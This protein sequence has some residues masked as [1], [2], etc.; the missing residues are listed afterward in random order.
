MFTKQPRNQGVYDIEEKIK[1]AFP[2]S[3]H[4]KETQFIKKL[5]SA[6]NT[7]TEE[8][9]KIFNFGEGARSKVQFTQYPNVCQNNRQ[10]FDTTGIFKTISQVDSLA[11]KVGSEILQFLLIV[12]KNMPLSR[13]SVRWK[14]RENERNFRGQL[15]LLQMDVKDACDLLNK[16][17]I[18]ALTFD[19]DM[20]SLIEDFDADDQRQIAG[21]VIDDLLESGE[22]DR[23]KNRLAVAK[24][25]KYGAMYSKLKAVE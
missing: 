25:R 3:D 22:V 11:H 16:R 1:K 20:K 7:V 24:V 13:R 8:D 19:N 15:L 21:N 6:L 2:K 4:I 12:R 23:S 10:I 9:I 14:E 17:V 18:S 5:K